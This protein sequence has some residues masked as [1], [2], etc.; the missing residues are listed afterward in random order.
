MFLLNDTI[1]NT[2]SESFLF[3]ENTK[4]KLVKL[5]HHCNTKKHIC[6]PLFS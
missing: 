6:K 3:V 4:Y 2:I 1:T 5:N